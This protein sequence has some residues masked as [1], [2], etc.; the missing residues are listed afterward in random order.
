MIYI[1]EKYRADVIRKKVQNY[2]EMSI[3]VIFTFPTKL[4]IIF[5]FLL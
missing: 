2:C 5:N 4:T 3:K 1:V